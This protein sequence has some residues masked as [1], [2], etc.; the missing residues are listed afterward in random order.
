M[1]ALE[2]LRNIFAALMIAALTYWIPIAGDM[3]FGTHFEVTFQRTSLGDK[4]GYLFVL[5]NFDSQKVDTISLAINGPLSIKSVLSDGIKPIEK[6]LSPGA[7]IL[8]IHD[9]LPHRRTN[10]IIET[11]DMIGQDQLRVYNDR[12]TFTVYSNNVIYKSLFER[13]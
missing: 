9:L 11:D 3:V 13:Y 6:T 4:N 2:V 12:G 7:S 5:D 10:I 8:T 1:S